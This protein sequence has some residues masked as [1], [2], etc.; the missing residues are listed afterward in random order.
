MSTTRR[1]TTPGLGATIR[2]PHP[3]G[4]LQH[5]A[6]LGCIWSRLLLIV[7]VVALLYAGVATPTEVGALCRC[8]SSRCS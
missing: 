6:S 3:I 1:W 5:W 4:R 8:C 7:L 2:A